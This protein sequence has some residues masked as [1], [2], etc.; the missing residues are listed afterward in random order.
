MTPMQAWSTKETYQQFLDFYDDVL[1]EFKNVEKM[2]SLRW[3]RRCSEEGVG[4]EGAGLCL[5]V[6]SMH[7][8][9]YFMTHVYGVIGRESSYAHL[10]ENQ[11]II[12]N[13]YCSQLD[14]LK[15][16]SE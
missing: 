11:M 3:A 14:Q 12:S 9:I 13:K 6:M 7:K 8:Y 15:A 10:L 2:I 4:S 1:P 16:L 5:Y